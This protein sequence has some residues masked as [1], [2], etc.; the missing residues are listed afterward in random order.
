MELFTYLVASS[1][2][3]IK[4]FPHEKNVEIADD[5][6]HPVPCVLLVAILLFLMILIS[7]LL[8]NISRTTLDFRWPPFIKTF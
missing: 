6:V 8:I 1:Q 4:L 7:F 5:K 2:D 3:L